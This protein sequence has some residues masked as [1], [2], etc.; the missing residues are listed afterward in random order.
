M[1]GTRI[2]LLDTNI[3]RL[4]MR[5]NGM[6]DPFAALSEYPVVGMSV[7]L[8]PCRSNAA[9]ASGVTRLAIAPVSHRNRA[10]SLAR[11]GL[12]L[13]K[14][15]SDNTGHPASPLPLLCAAAPGGGGL[16]ELSRSL[17]SVGG[18]PH[19]RPWSRGSS[20]P[21]PTGQGTR[22]MPLMSCFG[23]LEQDGRP[24][25]TC[26]SSTPSGVGP[27]GNPAAVWVPAFLP[28]TARRSA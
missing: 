16:L 10:P 23:S 22:G 25:A 15:R 5:S 11:D 24:S 27:T 26:P 8:A 17:I 18:P 7:T 28:G 2:S 4:T 21:T 3:C 1:H 6:G 9:S 14:I 12:M 13:T 19:P 20:S